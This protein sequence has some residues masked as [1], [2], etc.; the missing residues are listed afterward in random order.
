MTA[1]SE[2]P[3]PPTMNQLLVLHAIRDLTRENG[4]APTYRELAAALYYASPNQVHGI[5]RRLMDR[6]WLCPVPRYLDRALR[7]AHEIPPLPEHPFEL[8]VE[9][10]AYL[11]ERNVP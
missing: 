1:I 8:T 7:I 2:P 5:C 6:G 3:F 4:E 11:S 10:A 9:G